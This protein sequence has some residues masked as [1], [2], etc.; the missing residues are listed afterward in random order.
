[1][2]RSFLKFLDEPMKADYTE[3]IISNGAVEHGLHG[4][5][6][7]TKNDRYSKTMGD[8]TDKTGLRQSSHESVG[9]SVGFLQ[10]QFV[11]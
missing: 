3:S 8:L 10:M 4:A 5:I 1:M 7:C 11:I 6:L 2:V 9:Q